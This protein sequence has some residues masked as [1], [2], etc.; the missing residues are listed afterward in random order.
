MY[1]GKLLKVVSRLLN[2]SLHLTSE[3]NATALILLQDPGPPGLFQPRKTSSALIEQKKKYGSL[4]Q[5]DKMTP[6]L[7]CFELVPT[8]ILSKDCVL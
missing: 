8:G 4:V 3:C 7:G 6:L 5:S 2:Q 1:K